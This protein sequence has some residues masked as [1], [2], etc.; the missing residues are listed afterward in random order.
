MDLFSTMD[1]IATFFDSE[2]TPTSSL[3]S[4]DDSDIFAAMP[5]IDMEHGGDTGRFYCVIS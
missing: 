1:A 2:A 3:S 5:P 4:L